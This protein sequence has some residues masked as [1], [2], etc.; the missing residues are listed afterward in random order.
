[1]WPQSSRTEKLT[2]RS[3]T[4]QFVWI[5]P[6]GESRTATAVTYFEPPLA[7]VPSI[8]VAN[9]EFWYTSGR[10]PVIE[11]YSSDNKRLA[12]IA[13]PIPLKRVTDLDR[14]AFEQQW[15]ARYRS[16][17]LRAVLSEMKY[18]AVLPYV[19][20]V[21]VDRTGPVWIGE[22]ARPNE[23]LR[24]WRVISPHA[25]RRSQVTLPRH[26]QVMAASGNLVAGI[27]KDSLGVEYVGLYRVR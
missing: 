16:N 17:R 20:H 26:F 22:Y 24:L 19:E 9:D 23:P 12:D 1:L 21:I 7:S 10:V 15:R 6:A 2:T 5:Q 18:P 3:W 13:V 4:D 8:I 14:R 11:R 25:G 27:E